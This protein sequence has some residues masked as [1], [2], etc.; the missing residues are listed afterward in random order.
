MKIYD[1][2]YQLYSQIYPLFYSEHVDR[3]F[4]DRV[5]QPTWKNIMEVGVGQGRLIPHFLSYDIEHFVGLDIS[6]AMLEKIPT[7]YLE[8]PRCHCLHHDFLEFESPRK[9]DLITYTYNT[10]NYMLTLEDAH[11]HL[12]HC[13]NLLSK[14]GVVYFD[15]TFPPCLRNGTTSQTKSHVQEGGRQYQLKT[16]HSYDIKGNL[17]HRLFTCNIIDDGRPVQELEWGSYRRYYTVEDMISI[18]RALG[19]AP[20]HLEMYLAEDS[21]YYD[22]YFLLLKQ[23][24]F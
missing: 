2:E 21:T 7:A 8:N 15:M 1:D 16:Q 11:R 13:R 12:T 3:N 19:F 9:F 18:G 6:E 17:E 20:V 10:F 4:F 24:P 22:G 14:D 5:W 23:N